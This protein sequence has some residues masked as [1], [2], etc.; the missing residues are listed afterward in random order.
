MGLLNSMDVIINPEGYEDILSLLEPII[1]VYLRE[2]TINTERHF[3]K[4]ETNKFLDFL[5]KEFT[6]LFEEL[7]E[8]Y[9]SLEYEGYFEIDDPTKLPLDLID[10][11]QEEY[12]LFLDL[13][14]EDLPDF[15]EQELSDLI[16][17]FIMDL[18]MIDMT[19]KLESL[20]F[21][22]HAWV[23]IDGLIIDF[24][25]KQFESTIEPNESAIKR[26]KRYHY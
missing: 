14:E 19:E 5:K 9:G 11:D 18:D 17:N 15:T 21:I 3:C 13:Y 12:E 10:L 6:S 1:E 23:D 24:T 4:I 25:W 16:F 2:N 8:K 20:Y 7:T 22:D 26:C